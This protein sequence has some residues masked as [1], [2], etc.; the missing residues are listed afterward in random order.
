MNRDKQEYLRS[1]EVVARLGIGQSTL[2]RWVKEGRF[3]QPIRAG[4]RFTR[5]RLSDVERWEEDRLQA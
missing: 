3:P 1:Q 4:K 5:W 2:F